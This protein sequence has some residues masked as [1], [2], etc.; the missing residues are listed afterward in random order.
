M[1]ERL[2]SVELELHSYCNRQC[3]WCPNKTLD[4]SFYEEMP[5]EMFNSIIETLAENNFSETIS[6]TG[7]FEPMS[8]IELLKNRV[9]YIHEKLP[10][11]RVKVNTNGDFLNKENLDGLNLYKLN[12]NDYDCK[13]RFACVS[14][15]INSGCENI[16]NEL[17]HLSRQSVVAS[18]KNIEFVEYRIDW[19]KHVKLQDRGG[20][21]EEDELIYKDITLQWAKNKAT[22][23]E[24]CVHTID[25]LVIYYN[26]EVTF[27]TNIRPDNPN[28]KDFIIGNINK[29]TLEEIYTYSKARE[30]RDSLLSLCFYN[31]P[32]PCKRCS[33]KA[34][35]EY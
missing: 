30:F 32:L 16:R 1:F 21:F 17:K 6:F 12:I 18:H 35:Y 24:I 29:N 33:R 20:Y 4:R 8:N 15:L 25:N 7:Y 26:G 31:Y 13:G 23:T 9:N 11:A 22:R 19:P 10:N 3:T 34:Q 14:K 5:E 27:C 28:H 2:K